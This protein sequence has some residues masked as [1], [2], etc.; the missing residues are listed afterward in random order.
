MAAATA[1]ERKAREKTGSVLLL[2]HCCVCVLC[3]NPAQLPGIR[4]WTARFK[5]SRER[6]RKNK[7]KWS[8]VTCNEKEK[9]KESFSLSFCYS[10]VLL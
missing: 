2:P 4:D 7:A 10:G 5:S 9:K 1:A 8:C 6:E 3:C